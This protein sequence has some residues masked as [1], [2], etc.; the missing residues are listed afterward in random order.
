MKRRY[1]NINNATQIVGNENKKEE[2]LIKLKP[3]AEIHGG[4]LISSLIPM[5]GAT[6]V[7]FH[8]P[9]CP[10]HKKSKSYEEQHTVHLEPVR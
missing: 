1:K 4:V 8:R 9:S 7:S 5:E 10:A 3:I 6:A 2:D